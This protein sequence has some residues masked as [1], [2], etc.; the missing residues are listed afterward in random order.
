MTIQ[1]KP[2]VLFITL[3]YCCFDTFEEAHLQN[4]KSI[5]PLYEALVLGSSTLKGVSCAWS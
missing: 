2:D 1:S 4:M 5:G 3:N